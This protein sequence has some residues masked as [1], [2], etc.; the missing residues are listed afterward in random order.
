MIT[1][2]PAQLRRQAGT[3]L[4]Q[5]AY[6]PKKL[7]LIHAA[8]ALGGSL[9]ITAINYF[10]SLQIADT[11]GLGGMGLR[12]VLST[13]QSVLELAVMVLLPFWEIGLLF[14][15]LRWA[16]GESANVPDLLEGL[17][18]FGA[19]FAFRLLYGALFLALGFSIFYCS[20][21]LFVLTPF[22]NGFTDIIAPLMQPDI[23]MEQVEAIM[24]PA[25]ME[26]MA[27]TMTP[28]FILFGILYAV[29]A[30]PLFYRLRF[31][32]FAL[33]D[34][35]RTGA[36]MLQS[37]HLTKKRSLQL[38]KLDLHFWWYYL[39]QVL[40]L[41][42]S[43]ADTLLPLLGIGLPVSAELAFFLFYILGAVCQGL[44]LWQCQAKV[45][46]TYCLAYNAFLPPVQTLEVSE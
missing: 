32:E 41:V 15:A 18:R 4:G 9:L 3:L 29:A 16:N 46:T 24:T 19:V 11:G 34:G 28:L 8:I 5:A 44:L 43:W 23:T 1:I 27:G 45:L 14:A 42:L 12:S 40:C 21:T 7:V 39:L 38:V 13:V 33:M 20:A 25:F 30:I 17:R 2:Q 10:F 6:N 35:E 31:A 26:N 37:L 36:A 22:S